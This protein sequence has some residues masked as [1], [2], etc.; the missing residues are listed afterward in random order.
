MDLMSKKQHP[1]SLEDIDL[2]PV[3]GHTMRLHKFDL[4]KELFRK[5]VIDLMRAIGGDAG[6]SRFV[7]GC[8]RNSLMREPIKDIDIATV[9]KP[10]Q[11]RACVEAIGMKCVDTGLKHGTV[12]V[13][14]ETNGVRDGTFEV[15]TLRRDVSTDGRHAEV[16]FTDSWREDAM[17]RD[18]TMNALYATIKLDRYNNW[19]T[20]G[21]VYDYTNGVQDIIDR[22]VR[23]IGN[24]DDRIKEDHLRILRYFRFHAR[25]G[26]TRDHASLDACIKAKHKLKELSGERI[27]TEMLNLFSIKVPHLSSPVSTIKL[28]A[29]SGI[30]DEVLLGDNYNIDRF[31]NMCRQDV[32]E[33]NKPDPLLRLGSLLTDIYH[34]VRVSDRWRLSNDHRNRLLDMHEAAINFDQPVSKNVYLFGKQ[35]FTDVVRLRMAEQRAWKNM[36]EIANNWNI[37]K[38]PINGNDIIEMGYDKGPQI[39]SVLSALETKWVDDGFPTITNKKAWIEGV[40]KHE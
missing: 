13:I 27:Q 34:V 15:T 29:H 30:L 26:Q 22:T 16:E 40:L 8:V 3:K 9:L 33:N 19:T 11:V 18:F 1:E 38:F 12:T 31:I 21:N 4:D 28:M 24:P 23:F 6:D 39:G 20:E 7:G 10:D 14:S 17:R 25:Y 37:P 32:A 5:P 2:N 36:L 35:T